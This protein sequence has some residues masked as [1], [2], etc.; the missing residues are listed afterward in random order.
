LPG[1]RR[2]PVQARHPPLLGALSRVIPVDSF[3][4]PL[5]GFY[6]TPEVPPPLNSIC[7][8]QSSFHLSSYLILLVPVP[9]GP[10]S[11]SNDYYISLFQ[12]DRL[13][14]PPLE[15]SLL[16]SLSGLVDCSMIKL[17]FTV[18]SISK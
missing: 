9:T 8:S 5:L 3:E 18:I 2:W 17:Y 14:S 10:Q 16:L 4:L 6:L 11:S 13:M 12:G 1:Y 7:L 15:P